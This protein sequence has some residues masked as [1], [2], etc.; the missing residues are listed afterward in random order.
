MSL[1]L[2]GRENKI[3]L[4]SDT[5][6]GFYSV[7]RNLQEDYAT[8]HQNYS[9]EALALLSRSD[10]F[11]ESVEVVQSLDSLSRIDD[12]GINELFLLSQQIAELYHLKNISCSN[13]VE[14][15]SI[16]AAVWKI[17]LNEKNEIAN[18][19]YGSD[20]T[21]AQVIHSDGTTSSI[22]DMTGTDYEGKGFAKKLLTAAKLMLSEQADFDLQNKMLD[23]GLIY[24][25]EEQAKFINIEKGWIRKQDYYNLMTP[26]DFLDLNDYKDVT[27]NAVYDDDKGELVFIYTVGGKTEN[28]F[29]IKASNN[30]KEREYPT[31]GGTLTS[32]PM[33]TMPNNKSEPVVPYKPGKFPKGTWL[34][35]SFEESFTEGYG[36]YKIRTNAIRYVVG[37]KQ[38]YDENKILIGWEEIKNEKGE[39]VLYEDGH[40]LIHGGTGRIINKLTNIEKL[41]ARKG[42]ND[43]KGTTHGCIRISNLDVYLIVEILRNYLKSKGNIE[44]EV[45]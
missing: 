43:Y 17:Y 21:K 6:T 45:K 10:D 18:V 40:L 11:I 33:Y 22:I 41:D 13:P 23:S 25:S 37:Y 28:L 34:I 12:D 19:E 38:K 15:I 3:K 35:E 44:L 26:K 32:S 39:N 1:N 9:E 27:V 8:Y 36:P 31:D 4:I 42:E 2:D 7:M 14:N 16:S 5:M 30:Q 20:K 29:V 24:I